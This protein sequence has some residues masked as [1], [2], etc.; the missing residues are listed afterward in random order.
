MNT[1]TIPMSRAEALAVEAGKAAE[2]V[3]AQLLSTLHARKMW[4]HFDA[5]NSTSEK[6][7]FI[8]G[9]NVPTP[10]RRRAGKGAA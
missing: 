6:A 2:D 5:K 1:F 7:V 10:T 9:V 8:Y 3:I 4:A